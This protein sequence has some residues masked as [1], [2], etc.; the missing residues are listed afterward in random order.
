MAQAIVPGENTMNLQELLHTECIITGASFA[1][2]EEVLQAVA[3]AAVN[4]PA[5]QNVSKEDVVKG[6]KAREEMGST[7]FG[8]GVAIPHCR[9]GNVTDFIV[10]VITVPGGVPFDSLD[11]KD[12][13]LV[14]FIIGPDRESNEHIRILS[15]VSRILRIPGMVDETVKQTEPAAVMESFLRYSRDEVAKGERRARQIC[16]VFIQDQDMFDDILQVFSAFETANV[17]VIEAKNTRE[18]LTSMPLF[19]GFWS[20]D[21]LGINRIIIALIDK[22]LVNETLRSIESITG[23]LDDRTDILVTVQDVFYAA[24][25]LET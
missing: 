13:R 11:E 18:Y 17:A 1:G 22:S 5:C 19:A 21:Y 24:G 9:L 23:R 10:G 4:C 3:G 7:G 15:L 2:K 16:H 20:D 14:V 8:N 12:V 6:L 25:S